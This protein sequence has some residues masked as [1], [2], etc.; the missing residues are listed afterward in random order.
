MFFALVFSI[1]AMLFN[2]PDSE[3]SLVD[4]VD[5]NVDATQSGRDSCA[6]SSVSAD[7]D[8]LEPR[9]P[10]G[11]FQRMPPAVGTV[12]GISICSDTGSVLGSHSHRSIS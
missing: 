2:V 12:L 3:G 4:I 10:I 1:H 7:S 11:V 5:S 9:A 8:A 6:G